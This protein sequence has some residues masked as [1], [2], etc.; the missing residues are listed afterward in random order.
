MI[1][2]L[3]NLMGAGRLNKKLQNGLHSTLVEVGKIL[4][5]EAREIIYHRHTLAS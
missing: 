4:A 2:R 5:E 3:A 1:S